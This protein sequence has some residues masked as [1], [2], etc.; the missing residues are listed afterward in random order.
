MKDTAMASNLPAAPAGRDDAGG[1]AVRS[2]RVIAVLC[3]VAATLGGCGRADRSRP[4]AAVPDEAAATAEPRP[5]ERTLRVRADRGGAEL[6]RFWHVSNFALHDHYTFTRPGDLEIL[7]Q[8]APLTRGVLIDFALGGRFRDGQEMCAAPGDNGTLHADF[9]L[10]IARVRAVLDAD[11]EPWLMLEKVPPALSDPPRWHAYGNTAPA[12]DY[13]MWY[14]YVRAAVEALVDAFGREQVAGWR[15]MVATEPDLRPAH[16]AG[17]REQFFEHLDVT[18]AAVR[19]ILPEARIS[20]GNILNPAFA[21]PSGEPAPDESPAKGRRAWGLDIIDHAAGGTHART[22]RPGTPMDFFSASWYTRVGRPT[23]EFDRA[24]RVMRRRLDRYAQF[25]GL[26]IDIREFGV[27]HDEH[28]R[29]LFAGD[30]SEWAASFYAAIAR[31]VYEHRVRAVFEWDY[32][33]Y[34]VM[35][36]RGQVMALL[37]RMVGGRQ[38]P[39]EVLDAV[40]AADCHAIACARDGRLL[41]LL[42]HHRPPR[43]D[44]P[45]EIVHLEIL[46]PRITRGDAWRLCEW[47]LDAQRTGWA[48]AFRADAEAAGLQPLATAAAFEGSPGRCYGPAGIDLFHQNIERYRKLARLVQTRRDEPLTAAD[49]QLRLT[50][51]LPGHSVRLLEL[52]P[53][54]D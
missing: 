21:E 4:G 31:R 52:T 13:A 16:W 22:G 35:H 54:G 36:P 1:A 42:Y 26:P 29:R 47:T 8:R 32:A 27:L 43:D 7:R 33:T 34:G 40:S 24:I 39:V 19:S 14:R 41:V 3:L 5:G 28:R 38:V 9:S 10:L 23:D 49:G 25:R 45:D 50:L 46:D 51:H 2:L 6:Y 37:E 11:L 20:P 17:T 30:S 48:R 53:L 12:A 18:V 44:G 15:F